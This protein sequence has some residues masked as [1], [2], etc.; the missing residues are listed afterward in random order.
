MKF[1]E[2][3]VRS[4]WYLSLLNFLEDVSRFFFL[5]KSII[6]LYYDFYCWVYDMEFLLVVIYGCGYFKCLFLVDII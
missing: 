5:L 4:F 1:S 2:F 6:V 3:F